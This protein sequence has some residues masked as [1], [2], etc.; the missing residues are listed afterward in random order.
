MKRTTFPTYEWAVSLPAIPLASFWCRTQSWTAEKNYERDGGDI[1]PAA[2][3]VPELPAGF[4]AAV[5]PGIVRRF[6]ELVK[7]LKGLKNYTPTIGQALGIEGSV[8][9]GPDLAIIQAIIEL[10]IVGNAVLIT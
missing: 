7:R 6:R 3:I 5:P 8:Q 9:T 1:A 2:Q 4:P 10:S